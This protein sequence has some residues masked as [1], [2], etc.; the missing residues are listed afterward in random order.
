[1]KMNIFGILARVNLSITRHA[2]LI[3]IKDCS[4]QKRL[5][6]KLVL[7]CKDEI[8]NITENSLDDKIVI[9]EK[10]NSI[11]HM[12]SLVVIHFFLLVVISISSFYH[13]TVDSIKKNTYFRIN[14]K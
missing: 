13:Y 4:Y 6:R 9:C 14:T 2:K 12:I 1:M 10:S 7:A 3:N 11:N 5:I 8:L